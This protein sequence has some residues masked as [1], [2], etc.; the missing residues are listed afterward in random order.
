MNGMSR[1]ATLAKARV[2]MSLVLVLAVTAFSPF[3]PAIWVLRRAASDVNKG[4]SGRGRSL[5]RGGFQTF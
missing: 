3:I 2:S 1:R 4:A 5:P